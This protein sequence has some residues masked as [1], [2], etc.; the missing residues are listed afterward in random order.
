MDILI[1]VIFISI[2]AITGKTIEKNHY[3]NIRQRE[4]A[5]IKKPYLTYGNK[6][7]DK[8]EIESIDFVTSDIVIGCDRFSSICADLKSIFGGN[9]RSFEATL[10]RGRREALLRLREKAHT[11]GAN[12]VINV[13]YD[14]VSL[15]PLGTKG[16]PL[17][18]ITAYG[19]AIRYV[20]TKKQ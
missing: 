20:R 17:V 18:A 4:I 5:L 9:V 2:C 15:V 19:T 1:L 13:K 10:D 16:G 3:K 6:I 7:F 14:S 11:L 8:K 12:I